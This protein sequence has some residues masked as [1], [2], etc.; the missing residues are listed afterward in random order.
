MKNWKT[1]LAGLVAAS[2][3]FLASSGT[4]LHVAP[5]VVLI[6]KFI[7]GGGL[8]ALGILAKDGA[9]PQSAATN[10]QETSK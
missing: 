5:A 6:A 9:A 4:D 8:A 3:T 2:A 1:T 10:E 7:A